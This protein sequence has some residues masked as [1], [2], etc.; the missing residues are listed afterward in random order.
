LALKVVCGWCPAVIVGAGHL[1]RDDVVPRLLLP[2]WRCRFRGHKSVTS[3]ADPV[4][5]RWQKAACRSDIDAG[6]QH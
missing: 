2:W 5:T 4:D 6:Q 1:R 3:G